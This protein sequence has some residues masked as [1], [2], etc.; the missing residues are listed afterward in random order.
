MVAHLNGRL[1]LGGA[2]LRLEHLKRRGEPCREGG[3]L[4]VVE[5]GVERVVL[6]GED[7]ELVVEPPDPG[8]REPHRDHGPGGVPDGGVPLGRVELA[9]PVRRVRARP[10][11]EVHVVGAGDRVAEEV[12]EQGDVVG[13]L[14]HRVGVVELGE[15]GVHLVGGLFAGELVL[16]RAGASEPDHHRRRRPPRPRFGE[17]GRGQLDDPRGEPRR[18]EVGRLAHVPTSGAGGAGGAGAVSEGLAVGAELSVDADGLAGGEALGVGDELGEVG[19][20][21]GVPDPESDLW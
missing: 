18:L 5:L 19:G 3:D 11:R 1:P 10:E 15:E 2:S 21:A 16:P 6:D 14:P 13:L 9:H 7:V 17:A 12:V 8:H 20:A 4:F